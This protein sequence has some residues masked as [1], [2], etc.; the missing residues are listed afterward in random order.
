MNSA[1]TLM[2]SRSRAPYTWYQHACRSPLH[3]RTKGSHSNPK[4]PLA[5]RYC[6][7][8]VHVLWHCG[9]VRVGV[10]TVKRWAHE[11]HAIGSHVCWL[12]PQHDWES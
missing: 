10:A 4:W 12:Q 8:A 1:T 5:F 3:L 9:I 11:R 7:I 2:M 6:G